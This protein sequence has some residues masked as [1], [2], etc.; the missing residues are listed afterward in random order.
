M[1]ER[2]RW[3]KHLSR[4]GKKY[5]CDVI[6]KAYCYN[7]IANGKSKKCN[8]A[9]EEAALDAI[10]GRPLS[11]RIEN[12]ARCFKCGTYLGS[13]F[14]A[15]RIYCDKCAAQGRLEDKEKIRKNMND[16]VAEDLVHAIIEGLFR[17]Y[18]KVLHKIM[19]LGDN[20]KKEPKKLELLKQKMKLEEYMF[21]SDFAM[22]NSGDLN[23]NKIIEAIQ[24]Q[25]GYS[26][27]NYGA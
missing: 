4:Q 10:S 7:S 3:C 27:D 21:S 12:E 13:S 19:K 5:Y 25:V 15:G 26:E 17:D 11:E 24:A 20:I 9:Y 22:L 16:D 23:I 14:F 1:I 2:C 8:N 6:D 18:T